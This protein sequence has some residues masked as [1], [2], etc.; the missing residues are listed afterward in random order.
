MAWLSDR[1]SDTE[2]VGI[3]MEYWVTATGC[4]TTQLTDLACIA[5]E[6]GYTG[7]AVSDH[8]FHPVALSTPYPYSPDGS[9]PWT[10]RTH[11][12]DPFTAIAAMAAATTT[13]R[14]TTNVYVAPTRDVLTVAKS[15]ATAA[16]LSEVDTHHRVVFGV[17]T[18]WCVEEFTATG[19]PYHQR[20][21]RLDAMLEILRAYWSGEVSEHHNE[22]FQLPAASI[23]PVPADP[24]PVWIGGD[25]EAA[26]HR[27]ARHDGWFGLHYTPEQ[28]DALLDRLDTIRGGQNDKQFDVIVTLNGR[29]TSD[30]VTHLSGRGV[31][32]MQ[33]APWMRGRADP[34]N[35]PSIDEKHEA[36]GK[37]A[38]RYIG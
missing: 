9:R 11:W 32:G 1:P 31:T 30:L 6:F 13:L 17:G 18:G 37:F 12:P 33:V 27:A 20:G 25:S 19:Q 8:V 10:E 23:A 36:L 24:I 7:V 15:V 34:D 21:K 26:L 28:A 35:D 38:A 29:L 3:F 4:A 16:V 14:F 2:K 5:E 22:F